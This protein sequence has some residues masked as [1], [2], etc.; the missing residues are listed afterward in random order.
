MTTASK[1][2]RLGFLGVG[3]IALDHVA[4]VQALGHEVAAGCAT[5]PESPRWMK[6]KELAKDSRYQQRGEDLLS[7]PDVDAVVACLPWDQTESWLPLHRR[8]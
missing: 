2:V 4:A 7:S 8:T 5:S 6:F 3:A 1:T